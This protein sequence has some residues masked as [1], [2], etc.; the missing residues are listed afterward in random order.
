M[1]DGQR[2]RDAARFLRQRQVAGQRERQPR[3]SRDGNP[4][5]YLITAPPD[6]QLDRIT[7]SSTEYL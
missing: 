1:S 5:R 4:T 3:C 7:A 2:Q 6:R